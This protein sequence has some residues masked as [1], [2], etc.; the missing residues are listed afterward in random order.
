MRKAK[1]DALYFNDVEVGDTWDSSARTVT[2]ADVVNFAGITG[3]YN[4]LHVDHEFAR[5]TLFGKPIAH[6]LLGLSWAAGLG[7]L[8]PH[9]RTAAFV[10]ISE[11][12]FLKPIYIGDTVHIRTEILA[13]EV[14]GR[15]RRGLIRWKRQIL[16][17]S[18]A[19]VQEGVTET[20]VEIRHEKSSS[21]H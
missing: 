9:M 13:K 1:S 21:S 17:Q 18:G 14:R 10:R 20:L 4:P 2:E 6:G 11:W 3:D 16:N 5:S 7:S 12:T 15:G 19:V 8:S